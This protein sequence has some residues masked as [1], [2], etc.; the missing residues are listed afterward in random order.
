MT[1]LKRLSIGF[2]LVAALIGTSQ[3]VRTFESCMA[4]G[5][6]CPVNPAEQDVFPGP[7]EFECYAS[8]DCQ[9]VR[10]CAED[11]CSGWG[12]NWFCYTGGPYQGVAGEFLCIEE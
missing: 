1:I 3:E 5:F 6:A 2:F 9:V 8:V 7:Y 11:L 4:L 12:I 10:Y